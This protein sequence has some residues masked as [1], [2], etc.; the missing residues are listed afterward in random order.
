[1]VVERDMTVRG[2]DIV[3]VD[4]ERTTSAYERCRPQCV[5]VCVCVC[6]ET[7]LSRGEAKNKMVKK[8]QTR[9]IWLTTMSWSDTM[10]V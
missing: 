8:L 3:S 1:M 6:V 5:C 7:M 9:P 10:Y 2:K 4:F